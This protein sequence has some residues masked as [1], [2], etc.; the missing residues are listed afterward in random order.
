M[1]LGL[2]VALADDLE[3]LGLPVTSSGFVRAVRL[4]PPVQRVR[5]Q[6]GLDGPA[7]PDGTA[8]IVAVAGWLAAAGRA[9]AGPLTRREQGAITI[10]FGAGDELGLPRT[11]A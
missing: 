3:A 9:R 10:L 7:N 8:A 1:E 6:R 5:A 2:P 4:A 11:A